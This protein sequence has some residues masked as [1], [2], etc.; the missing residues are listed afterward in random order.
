M[1]KKELKKALR[2][3]VKIYANVSYNKHDTLYCLI[4]KTDFYN[5][6]LKMDDNTVFSNIKIDGHRIYIN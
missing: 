5:S 6:I 1:T 4:V 2:Q 3:C